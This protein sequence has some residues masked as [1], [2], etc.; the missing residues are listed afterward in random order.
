MEDKKEITLDDVIQQSLDINT[1]ELQQ[2]RTGQ[3]AKFAFFRDDIKARMKIAGL[4]GF[5]DETI[6]IKLEQAIKTVNGVRYKK[7]Q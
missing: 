5:S 2:Y 7:G 6:V 3:K 4:H 1:K